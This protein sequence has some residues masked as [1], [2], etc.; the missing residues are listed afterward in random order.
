MFLQGSETAPWTAS[1]VH[2]TVAAIARQSAYQRTVGESAMDR[3]F[4]L[5]GE[6][7]RKV[8]DFF[9]GSDAGRHIAIALAVMIVAVFVLQTILATLASRTDAM[10]PGAAPGRMRPADAWQ[11]SQRF[12][13]AGRF[14]DASHALLA[15]LLTAFAQRGEVRLHASKTAGDYARELARRG[16]PSRAAFRQFRR[17]YDLVIFG[18]GECSAD[19]YAALMR[20]AQPMLSA[21]LAQAGAR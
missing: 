9:R 13:A 16:S 8:Y 7:V 6:L 1:A 12:A 3:L 4:D 18:A 17:H 20:D 5:L 15:A 2:D 21:V 19:D 14:T 10:S 11:E